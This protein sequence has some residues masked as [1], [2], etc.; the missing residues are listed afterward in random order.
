LN[1]DFGEI[2]KSYFN[3][4]YVCLTSNSTQSP[5]ATFTDFD[6]HI[7]FLKEKYQGKILVSIAKIPTDSEANKKS[8]IDAIAEFINN[9][10]PVEK[11][12]W[13]SLTEQV[14]KEYIQKVSEAVNFLF[15]N[16]PKP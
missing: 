13:V 10:F 12:V 1:V 11:N 16:F 2:S 9:S 14:K 8:Y 6:S 4:S 15:N 7:R 5:F 3:N